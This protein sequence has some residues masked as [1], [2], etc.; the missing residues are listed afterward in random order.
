MSSPTIP[1]YQPRNGYYP[2]YQA[3]Q[4]LTS[5]NLNDTNDFLEKE[6]RATRSYLIGNGVVNGLDQ[7]TANY[8]PISGA[9][10]SIQ[11]N[12]GIGLTTDGY[13]LQTPG[14]YPTRYSPGTVIF[15]LAASRT[16]WLYT[17]TNPNDQNYQH[18]VLAFN[19]LQLLDE[20]IN[21]A[22][23]LVW[24][25]TYI[26]QTEVDCL[27]LFTGSGDPNNTDN[28]STSSIAT[29]IAD[30]PSSTSITL[31]NS[32]LV[33]MADLLDTS[34]ANCGVGSCNAQGVSRNIINR[35]LLI[36]LSY[37]EGTANVVYNT[38]PYVQIP[39]LPK[40]ASVTDINTHYA[41]VNSMFTN[42]Q[43]TIGNTLN[44]IRT[45]F[46]NILPNADMNAAM[47]K[48]NSFSIST[49][50]QQLTGHYYTLFMR[51]MHI[52]VTEYTKQ[53]NEV[54]YKYP[55]L[56]DTRIDRVLIL[57]HVLNTNAVDPFRY[58][59]SPSANCCGGQC[60]ILIL[61]KCYNR[62]ISMINS[63]LYDPQVLQSH[64]TQ[65]TQSGQ[66][67]IKVSRSRDPFNAL[68]DKSIPFYYDMSVN[69]N[70][71]YSVVAK[72]PNSVPFYPAS[73]Q[74]YP[75]GFTGNT[76]AATANN[77]DQNNT[78]VPINQVTIDTNNVNANNTTVPTLA[79][80]GVPT[81]YTGGYNLLQNWQATAVDFH[82]EQVNNYYLPP[83]QNPANVNLAQYNFLKVEGHVGLP[84]VEAHTALTQQYANLDVPV[85]IIHATPATQFA[86]LSAPLATG[87][88]TAKVITVG[89]T[90]VTT[91]QL[92]AYA[93]Q[94]TGMESKS[95]VAPASTHVL[96]NDGA[97]IVHCACIATPVSLPLVP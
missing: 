42:S 27:E 73:F 26:S 80:N 86:A 40:M 60:D 53:Y 77:L 21:P 39:G 69:L 84:I 32:V 66:S 74:D 10:T 47:N 51:D 52:A 20:F 6:I 96:I 55:D 57:G 43:T 31:D 36:P 75:T 17:N 11:V 59:F 82:I 79:C 72:A 76:G 3:D 93:T 38:L 62:I 46:P 58:Y 70:P 24:D 65:V 18:S 90:S 5:D 89:G 8:D 81:Q 14:Y 49:A 29:A 25:T 35:F 92:D 67:T 23:G 1:P 37:F 54:T 63:F 28:V 48:F 45:H 61:T 68:G 41:N 78:P 87:S 91:Y 19:D 85:T 30:T 34:N 16:M 44:T 71:S 2:V 4:F 7:L 15:T 13:L 94:L 56:N 83:V 50:T 95:G 97:N 9:L 64:M 88:T 33:L 22:T 12:A